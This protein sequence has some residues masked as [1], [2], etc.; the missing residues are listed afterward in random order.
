[1]NGP[2]IVLKNI[3]KR[4]KIGYRKNIGALARVLYF[5]SSREPKRTIEVLKDFSLTVN[6]GEIVGI[7]GLNGCG[8]S[9]ILRIIAGI[10]EKDKGEIIVNGKIISLINL[11]AGLKDRLTMRDNIYLL[12]SLFGM[13]TKEIKKKFHSIVNFSGLEKF[14]DTKLYQFSNGMLQRLAFSIAIHANPDI[15]LLDEVF[16]IGDEEFRKRSVKWI[17][18]FVRKGGCVVLVTHDLELVNKYCDRIVKI[19]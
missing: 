7:I 9:T 19:D 14:V 13:P 1:M 17:E 11:Y 18:G 8:K 2:K 10:Y 4:F 6:K 5:F 15:L 3:S 16:E 12:G